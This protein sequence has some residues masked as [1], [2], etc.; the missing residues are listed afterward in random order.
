MFC[1]NFIYNYIQCMDGC[2][3]GRVRKEVRN[4]AIRTVKHKIYVGIRW[5]RYFALTINNTV[6]KCTTKKAFDISTSLYLIGE[7]LSNIFCYLSQR[8]TAAHLALSKS[9]PSLSHTV[10]RTFLMA[11]INGFARLSHKLSIID[12]LFKSCLARGNSP[13]R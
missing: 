9:S 12:N 10:H 4:E 3:K 13:A 5:Q 1:F 6:Y 11:I 8:S 7:A 2:R